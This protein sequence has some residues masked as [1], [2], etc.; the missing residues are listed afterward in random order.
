MNETTQTSA[1]STDTRIFRYFLLHVRIGRDGT[2][3]RVPALCDCNIPKCTVGDE[4]AQYFR[5]IGLDVV[6]EDLGLHTIEQAQA[7][8]TLSENEASFANFLSMSFRRQRTV[9]AISD[10]CTALAAVAGD[11]GQVH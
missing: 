8:T 10:L 4:M 2:A 1:P 3:T 6:I 9:Q 5:S 11:K 7:Q